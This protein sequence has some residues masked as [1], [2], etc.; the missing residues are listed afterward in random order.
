MLI[1]KNQIEIIKKFQLLLTNKKLKKKIHKNSFNLY[2]NYYDV[3][4]IIYK[5]QK[6]IEHKI[7]I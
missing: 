5:N 6:I 1:A 7:N 3:N 2:K 4:K